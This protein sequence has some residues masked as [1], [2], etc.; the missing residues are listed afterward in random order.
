MKEVLHLGGGNNIGEQ[1]NIRNSLNGMGN[2][3]E[4]PQF[5]GHV[6]SFFKDSSDPIQIAQSERLDSII[7]NGVSLITFFGHTSS[8]SFDFS[9]D[10]PNNYENFGRLPIFLSMGCYSG[11]IHNNQP[12][13]LSSQFVFAENKGAIAFVA[14]TTLAELSS[15]RKMGFRYYEEFADLR[16]GESLGK[17]LLSTYTYMANNN[18]NIFDQL[19]F[20]HNTL[21]GDPSI[22]M[23][24]FIFPDYYIES[25][26]VDYE[27][28]QPISNQEDSIRLKIRVRNL[29]KALN[30][31]I[32]IKI[33]RTYPD[34]SFEVSFQQIGFSTEIRIVL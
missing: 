34:N 25:S 21:H 1:N 31:S 5:G 22:K 28:D 6:N 10:N 32:S 2:L 26:Y 27:H 13:A 9:I 15:L 7:D 8:N 14:S 3:V 33:T 19:L 29:G 17:H 23:Y 4:S 18:P 30:D 12:G 20:E 11:A 24:H 16:Y